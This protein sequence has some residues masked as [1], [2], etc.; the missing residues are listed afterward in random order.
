M[1]T[2]V[3]SGMLNLQGSSP[4]AWPQVTSTSVLLVDLSLKETLLTIISRLSKRFCVIQQKNN[5]IKLL[6]I[7]ICDTNI[8][9]R[10]NTAI[11]WGYLSLSLPLSSQ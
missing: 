8:H 1:Q 6:F 5:N 3:H 2:P 9:K 11:K 10:I 4:M 7:L